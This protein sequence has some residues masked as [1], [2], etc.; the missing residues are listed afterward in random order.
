[1]DKLNETSGLEKLFPNIA[2]RHYTGFENVTCVARLLATKPAQATHT[3][4]RFARDM[5]MRD[6]TSG[7]LVL[8]GSKQSN[9]WDTLFEDRLNFRVEYRGNSHNLRIV[10]RAPRTGEEEEYLPSPL[11]AT[12]R[13]IYGLIAFVPNLNH[14]SDVLI[15]QATSMAGTEVAL[16]TLA[17]PALFRELQRQMGS[18]KLAHFE[19]LIRTRTLNG[20]AG[21]SSILAT[22]VLD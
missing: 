5:T 17:N 1:V 3:A 16:E 10:N 7:N 13:D 6:I 18:G 14:E 22:R 8:L 11:D 20:T 9:P 12:T 2:L 19:A 4:V 15:L 21:E